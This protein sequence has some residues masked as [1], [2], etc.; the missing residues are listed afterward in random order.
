MHS[1]YT[2][3]CIR[4]FKRYPLL[5]PRSNFLRPPVL[6]PHFPPLFHNLVPAPTPRQA[7]RPLSMLRVHRSRH[8]PPDKRVIIAVLTFLIGGDR[9]GSEPRAPSRPFMAATPLPSLLLVPFFILTTSF[10]PSLSLVFLL[11]VLFL[12]LVAAAPL[13][14]PWR[15][16][17][18][19]HLNFLCQ[20]I[21]PRPPHSFP[22]FPPSYW[23]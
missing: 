16:P 17:P 6:V 1:I 14:S 4:T 15:A 8:N 9:G 21:L 19:R 7:A 2:Y 22:S 23:G 5:F 20:P 10:L 3:E 18:T 12:P 13:C 11:R